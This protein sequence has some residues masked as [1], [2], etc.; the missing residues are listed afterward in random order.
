MAYGHVAMDELE[1]FLDNSEKRIQLRIAVVK[2]LANIGSKDAVR[3]LLRELEGTTD[4]LETE[5]VDALDR[6][7]SEHADIEFPSKLA[8][9]VTLSLIKK[10]CLTFMDLHRMEPS[11]K[12]Q[13][14]KN[15]LEK[16][17]GRYFWDIFRVLGLTYPHED[18]V[19]A[20][21]NI[22]TGTAY[23]VAYAIELLDNTLKKDIKDYVIP[24]VEDL[25]PE[26]KQ[27]K[28][29]RMLKSL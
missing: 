29:L 9:K 18:I 16:K 8:R 11:G 24:L 19:K 28:F 10:Y 3:I 12:S 1:A 25:T 14:Q 21:Q 23:S 5:I 22:K 20:R 15:L 13:E 6:I 2:V 27:Q 4:E 26:Q 7:R 17:L